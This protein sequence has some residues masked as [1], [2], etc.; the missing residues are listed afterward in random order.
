MNTKAGS[1]FLRSSVLLETRVNETNFTTIEDEKVVNTFMV[2]REPMHRLLS[3]KKT[4]IQ[5]DSF[6]AKITR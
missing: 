4:W 1:V 2:I 3:G 6:N 5:V